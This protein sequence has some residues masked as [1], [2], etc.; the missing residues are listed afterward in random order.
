M[1]ELHN[2]VKKYS[3]GDNEVLALRGVSLKFRKN[4]FVSILG[5]SGCGKTTM[6]NIIGGLD[7]YT[8]GDLV[9]NGISTKEY[10]D[11]DWDTYRNHSIG[12]VFQSYNLIP[13]QTVLSNVEL[14][15]TLSGVSKHERRQRAKEALIKV[16]LGDQLH[17]RPSQMSGGQMQR[18]AIARALVNN[19]D[20]LLADEPTGA[21][22]TTTSVQIM[23]LLKEVASDR[24]V[25][26]VTHNP[27]LAAEYSTRIV[28]LSDGLVI[29]DTDP[30]EDE[31]VTVAEAEPTVKVKKPKKNKEKGKKAKT[32]MS[33]L[34]AISLSTKNLLTKKGRTILT[35]IA[36]SIGIIG[37]A[38]I[39]AV[40]QGVTG[41]INDVQRDTLSSFPITI[42]AEEADLSSMM[43]TMMDNTGSSGNV[44]KKDDAVYSNP[45]LFDLIHS[46]TSA[47]VKKNNLEPFK[48]W[49][50]SRGEHELG[51]YVSGVHYTYDIDLNM[52]VKDPN[53]EYTK[54][55]IADLFSGMMGESSSSMSMM[56]MG[57]SFSSVDVWC[58]MLPGDPAKDGEEQALISDMIYEQYDLVSG[59]WP[60]QANQVVLVLN[61]NNEISDIVLYTLG[62]ITKDDMLNTVISAM[63]GDDDYVSE[64]R[65][66]EY[67]DIIG[68]S[69]KLILNSDY[70]N[71]NTQTG[72]WDDVSGKAEIMK[73]RIE[74]GYDV[75]ITGIIKPDPDAS[76]TVL[77]GNLAYT[78]ALTSYIIEETAKTKLAEDQLKAEN[79]NFDVFTGLPFAK[80]EKVLTSA[81]K[82]AALNEYIANATPEEK[83]ELYL[84]IMATPDDEY[85]SKMLTMY[86]EQFGLDKLSSDELR[87]KLSE[88]LSQQ[89][90]LEGLTP[91][92]IQ[93]LIAS[94]SDKELEE[95]MDQYLVE[96]IVT[97]YRDQV[98]AEIKD[99]ASA[100][101]AEQLSQIKAMIEGQILAAIN[102]KMPEG[103]KATEMTA[104]LKMSTVAGIYAEK[105]GLTLI[106]YMGILAN[107]SAEQIAAM[108]DGILT[109]QATDFYAQNATP[110]EEELNT[111]IAAMLDGYITD[112]SEEDLLKIYDDYMPDGLSPNTYQDNLKLIGV[113]NK[114]KPSAIHIYAST[115]EAK[116]EIAALIEN[117]YNAGKLE[118]DKIS[119][120]DYV[121]I[122]MSS[123]TTIINAISYVLI[124]FVAIS[125]VVS[126]VMIGIITN[127][128]VLERTKEIGIL[129][130]IGASKRDISRVFNAETFIIGL[131]AGLIGIITTM[132]LC[133]PINAI[134]QALTEINNITAVLPPVAAAIL[135][136]ISMALTMIAGLIP[137][138]NASKKD[139][140]EALRSE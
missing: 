137:A 132:I 131:A 121:A 118:E 44:E 130:A 120:T 109:E 79:A 82:I 67:S 135:V 13:H 40:S 63:R 28:K 11:R 125:L 86:K 16:G 94:Y 61:E 3:S 128:S 36:G 10:K 41:Y 73:L 25:I 2:I 77:S 23:D 100:P 81:E 26:M 103:M 8:D 89:N 6:L 133:I 65:R 114:E 46:M 99:K 58:E 21:L 32:S 111:R 52:Y 96:M 29:D 51:E 72:L 85:V 42:L 70:Y 110:S 19:P 116:D 122:L 84:D 4:E 60:T 113:C 140:V 104:Q 45:I 117:N 33:F 87:I 75:T 37:I 106:E 20:I 74:N 50:D 115:F 102:Q 138:R 27:E 107:Y 139:P 54:A 64:T 49:L 126:S 43:S 83:A 71:Y 62:Y 35:S 78:S 57:S 91:E 123:I 136:F 80:V 14:A 76:S 9:I 127:I 12:F 101:S 53:G 22:D 88:L 92:S 105:T 24:L 69:Y 31:E 56:N 134:I 17:K 108:Y 38:L 18:V 119:Y 55:E 34:T 47:E 15:L 39:L 30:Y 98:T 129:R 90:Q 1:L 66:I 59:N 95:M 112:A 68:K 48:Q 5:A 124:A 7:R 97:G 93:A